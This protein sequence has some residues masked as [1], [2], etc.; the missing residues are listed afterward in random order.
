MDYKLMHIGKSTARKKK[1]NEVVFL[2]TDLFCK[3]C[4]GR[5]VE[6]VRDSE[7]VLYEVKEKKACLSSEK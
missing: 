6:M 5:A 3:V 7:I 4:S 1:K 2:Q